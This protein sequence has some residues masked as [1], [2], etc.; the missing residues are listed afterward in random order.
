MSSTVLF[1]ASVHNKARG[2]TQSPGHINPC[3][4]HMHLVQ[5]KHLKA[6]EERTNR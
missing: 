2:I 6:G 3:T 5:I 1:K 4:C